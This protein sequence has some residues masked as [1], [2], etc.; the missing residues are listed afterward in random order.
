MSEPG[1]FRSDTEDADAREQ[2]V[3][4]A[5]AQLDAGRGVPHEAVCDWLQDLAAG[6]R[7]PTPRL[8]EPLPVRHDS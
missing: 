5:R 7:R 6:R 8:N 2:A 3:A 4:E 1:Q